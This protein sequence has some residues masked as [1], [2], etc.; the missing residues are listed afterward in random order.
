[1][2]TIDGHVVE[3]RATAAAVKLPSPSTIL[4]TLIGLLPFLLGWLASAV[5]QFVT[6]L[7]AATVHGW[8][9]GQRQ[10]G[11]PPRTGGS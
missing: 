1:M 11:A 2:T 9:T 6:L 10:M 7:F 5:A 8:R 4:V 3:V